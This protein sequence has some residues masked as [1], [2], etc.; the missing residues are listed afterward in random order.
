[1]NIAVVGA[2][3]VGLVVAACLADF[4]FTVQCVDTD[5]GRIQGLRQGTLP[6]YEPGLGELVEKNAKAGRL[7]F[8]TDVSEGIRSSTV[9]FVAVGTEGNPGSGPD[10]R[11]VY[12]VAEEIASQLEAYKVIVLK[13]TVPVG[14]AAAVTDLIRSRQPRPVPFDVVSNPEFLREGSAIETF[15]R[16]DRVVIGTT[17]E[18]ARKIMR[19]IYRPLFL[20]ETPIV[21]T[22]NRNAELIKYAANAFLATKISFINEMAA[23]CDALGCD[24]HVVAKAIGLDRRIGPKF[25]HPGPGF[26]GSCLPKDGRGLLSLGEEMGIELEILKAVFRTNEGQAAR[27]VSKARLHLGSLAGRTIAVLGLAYKTNTD[28]VRE[29]PAIRACELFLREGASLRLHDPMA[30]ETARQLLH[31]P[32]VHYCAD[33][34]EAAQGADGVAVLTEW[35]EFRRLDLAALKG[36]LRGNL[37]LDARNIFDPEEVTSLGFVYVGVGRGPTPRAQE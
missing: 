18:T 29:S 11:A 20:I 31:G 22:T 23:L 35:N 27:V 37:L 12:A 33:P 2:G 8:S 13:S 34:Y 9:V 7:L 21:A 28:D 24:V 5:A 15:M 25:L 6:F 19:E 26:G 16:P 1:M 14:T 10:L 3:H 36:K 4:G 30:N 32:Q 17:S